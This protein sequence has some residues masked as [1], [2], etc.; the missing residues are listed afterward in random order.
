MPHC[1][2]A[3]VRSSNQDL[4]YYIFYKNN[5]VFYTIVAVEDTLNLALDTTFSLELPLIAPVTAKAAL[6]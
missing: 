4:V 5:I 1:G 6:Y 3:L 2:L